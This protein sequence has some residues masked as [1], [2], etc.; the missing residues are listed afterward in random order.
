MSKMSGPKTKK[1]QYNSPPPPEKKMCV[2]EEGG[3][4]VNFQKD[5]I[6]QAK[7]FQT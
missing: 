2:W 1:V 6:P 7:S 5:V 3:G 4:V